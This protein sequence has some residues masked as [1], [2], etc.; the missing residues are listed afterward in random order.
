M[1]VVRFNK[2]IFDVLIKCGFKYCY[3]RTIADEEYPGQ[4]IIVLTPVKSRP[5]IG[6]FPKSYDTCFKLKDEPKQMATRIDT[7]TFVYINLN[8]TILKECYV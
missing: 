3:S 8:N 4:I 1:E 2:E 7:N 6:K 5:D